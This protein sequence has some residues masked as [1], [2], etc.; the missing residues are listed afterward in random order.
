MSRY[1][2]KRLQRK[3]IWIT[4]LILVWLLCSGEAMASPLAE[5][6]AT[7]PNWSNKPPVQPSEGDLVYPAWMDGSWRMTSTLLKME[8]PLAPDLI[9]PGFEG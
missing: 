2:L 8:A 9:T 6:I 1:L 3:A 4:L 7:F 5:R